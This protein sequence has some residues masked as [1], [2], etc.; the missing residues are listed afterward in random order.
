MMKDSLRRRMCLNVALLLGVWGIV[1]NCTLPTTNK[2]S[3]AVI[4]GRILVQG[5]STPVEGALVEIL[6]LAR[7][8]FTDANGFFSLSF[9]LPDSGAH[10]ITLIISK[11]GFQTSSVPSIIIQND[12]EI[13]LADHHLAQE[14]T[15]NSGPASNVILIEVETSNI[16]VKGTG[17]NE[18]SD[19]TFEV[20]DANGTPIN[21]KNQV[22]VNFSIKGGPGGNEFLSP[23]S[24]TT[25]SLGQVS[26]TVN[27]G[28]IAGALQVV[29]SIASTTIASAPVPIAIHG[30]LPDL[31]HFAVVPNR[32]N[33][34]GFNIFG[35]ENTIT[36]F[37]GD[38]YS[39]PVP[40]RTVVYFQTTGGII[41]GSAITDELGRAAVTLLST[42]ALPQGI[43]G[44]LFP[45]NQPGFA[46]VI[47]Q[48]VDEKQQKI[49]TSA[50]VLFSGITQ[51]GI[52]PTTFSIPPLRSQAFQYTVSDQNGNP[53]VAGTNISVAT[54]EGEVAGTTGLTLE[55][56]QSRFFTSFS[57]T[58]TNSA[59]DSF[60]VKD[61]TVTV[62]VQSQNGNVKASVT[63]QML[64]IVSGGMRAEGV[65]RRAGE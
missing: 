40:P 32:L 6:E 21:L 53:L 42:Y 20:R 7:N 28:T 15:T 5:S 14:K 29:A 57:F 41:E 64:P 48:T 62:N 9:E 49:T 59:P 17:G 34:A 1:L 39:N 58:L 10:V 60:L 65:L 4:K 30:G 31:G 52:T 43:P 45:F 46:R 36:A 38:R 25:D 11:D 37:V 24:A 50:V 3:P 51:I 23:T 56:T 18:T 16:F 13:S 2:N 63:G 8:A 44:A 55:D 27:S 47:A 22:T 33:F 26:T 35:L 54:D 19:L 61:A 12:K